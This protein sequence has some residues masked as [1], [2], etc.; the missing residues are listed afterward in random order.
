MVPELAEYGP[1]LRA[2]FERVR[3]AKG[4]VFMQLI[5]GDRIWGRCCAR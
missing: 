3:D 4:P 5:H 1:A 2:A